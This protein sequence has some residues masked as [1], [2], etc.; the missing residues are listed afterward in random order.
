[1]IKTSRKISLLLFFI[2]VLSTFWGCSD[3]AHREGDNSAVGDS[4]TIGLNAEPGSLHPYDSEDFQ[5][6]YMNLLTNSTLFRCNPKTLE[7]EPYLVESYNMV[8]D[9]EWVFKIRDNIKFH[10]GEKMTSEDVKAS[11][12]FA[13]T[14]DVIKHKTTFWK[15]VE[16]VDDLTFK[17]TTDGPLAVTL[18]Y[19]ADTHANCIVP[20]S[21]I[22]SGHDFYTDPI[23]SGPYKLVKWDHGEKISF[24]KF[25]DYWDVNN[26]PQITNLTYKFIPENAARTIALETGEVD[27]IFNVPGTD[28]EKLEMNNAITV[29][30]TPSANVYALRV[31]NQKYP[32]NNELFRKA[33]CA[34]INKKDTLTVAMNDLGVVTLGQ[35]SPIFQGYSEKNS[36]D[37]DPAL[38]KQYL[39]ESGINVSSLAPF[40][41]IISSSREAYARSAQVVQANLMEL[42][43]TMDIQQMDYA[44]YKELIDE[45]D[46]DIGI[47]AVASSSMLS[48]INGC[49]HSK[50]AFNEA[51][52]Y[53]DEIDALIENAM[54]ET[55]GEERI[56]IIT[57]VAERVNEL[58]PTIPLFQSTLVTAY[59]S[60]LNGVT[61][62]AD[63]GQV[64]FNEVYWK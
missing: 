52:F 34:A 7:P 36:I 1:M 43:I 50:G 46:Y 56:A 23:G 22:E 57:Q 20:K 3:N 55:N 15:S 51:N 10:N 30:Q 49:W 33:L 14:F 11:L 13:S 44:Q 9:S 28:V 17:I 29:E 21:L 27:L 47:G 60:N 48:N 19:L 40:T 8:N 45:T 16:I 6:I 2:L 31:N 64:Y 39:T 12:E 58:C 54:T 32:F 25:D 42:G 35:I 5:V 38:A 4:I 41:C 53:N 61:V 62:A 26:A 24:V 63:F 59:N 37:Y 18:Y